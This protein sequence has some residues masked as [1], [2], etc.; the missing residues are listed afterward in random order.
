MDTETDADS[1]TVTQV[2]MRGYM[3]G[4]RVLRPAMVRVAE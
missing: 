3:H 2:M 1:G 4:E